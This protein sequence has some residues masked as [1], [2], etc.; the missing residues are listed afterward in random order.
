MKARKNISL[1]VTGLLVAVGALVALSGSTQAVSSYRNCADDAIVRC[2]AVTESELMRHYNNNVSDVQSIYS[3]YGIS[4]SDLNGTTSEIK[5]GTVYQDGRVVVDDEVVA[6]NAYSVSRVKYTSAGTPRTINVNGTTLYEGPNMGVFVR[7]VDAFV[8]FRDGQFYRA[9]LSACANPVKAT[10]VKPAPKPKPV[11]PVV[12]E[13]PVV[14]EKEV[15]VEKP[16]VVEKE[17]VV[18]KP[19]VVEKEVVKEV[20]EELPYTG[21]ES[22]VGG[23]LGV[24]SLTAAGYYWTASRKKLSDT[25][26]NR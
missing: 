8:M 12:I 11:K 2:G 15:T 9:I 16:V 18:E 4:Q 24:G 19:V 23:G 22:I 20:P 7:P 21:L 6:R 14:V 3:R 5:H 25:L 10:P 26:R 13:K 17:V 1:A